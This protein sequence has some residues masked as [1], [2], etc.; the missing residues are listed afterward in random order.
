MRDWKGVLAWRGVRRR[1]GLIP[2][3]GYISDDG[4]HNGD[5][6]V[7]A[8]ADDGEGRRDERP[9]DA[10]D[11]GAVDDEGDEDELQEDA[12][13]GELKDGFAADSMFWSVVRFFL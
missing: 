10:E 3:R 7:D 4:V 6:D 9:A 5:G 2:F 11:V 13:V 1:G 12:G 8:A